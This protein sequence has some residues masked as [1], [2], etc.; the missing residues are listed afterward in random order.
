MFY[1][2]DSWVRIP[3]I[4]LFHLFAVKYLGRKEEDELKKLVLVHL[5]I[6][7][8]T[9]VGQL[10]S[11]LCD[12]T[13]TDVADGSLTALKKHREQYLNW[14][15]YLPNVNQSTSRALGRSCLFSTPWKQIVAQS[16]KAIKAQN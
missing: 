10:L 8:L 5:L 1:D 11:P 4:F 6:N 12:L 16:S 9:E 2:I 14:D 15:N 7:E 3:D 13:P